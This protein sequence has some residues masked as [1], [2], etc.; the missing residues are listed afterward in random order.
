[1]GATNQDNWDHACLRTDLRR[2][3]DRAGGAREQ[4]ERGPLTALA[5]RPLGERTT[6]A[7]LADRGDG[8]GV[9]AVPLGSAAAAALAFLALGAAEPHASPFLHGLLV[10]AA[11]AAVWSMSQARWRLDQVW[12]MRGAAVLG[13]AVSS[14][15]LVRACPVPL[16]AALVVVVVMACFVG[17]RVLPADPVLGET[18]P[19]GTGCRR[20]LPNGICDVSAR[21]SPSSS[22]TSSRTR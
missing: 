8:G 16:A 7:G 13:A 21:R 22:T 3:G 4:G 18:G 17:L 10:V 15:V 11:V 14:V 5:E 9:D 20:A 6:A 12:S 2:G 1:M 19:P